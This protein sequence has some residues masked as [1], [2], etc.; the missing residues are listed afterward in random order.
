MIK[1]YINHIIKTEFFIVFKAIYLNITR[2]ENIQ[3]GFR[4]T[5]LIPYDPQVILSK[6]DV[7]L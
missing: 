3:T 7:K 1:A 2:P 5:G 4:D 6:L